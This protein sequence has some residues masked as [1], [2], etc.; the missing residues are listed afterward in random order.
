MIDYLYVI[1]DTYGR[2][3]EV[4]D[5][6]TEL[7]EGLPALLQQGWRPV[8]ETPFAGSSGI[9]AYILILL[10]RDSGPAGRY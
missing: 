4:K 3:W 9:D 6:D 5:G 8:R 2:C 1:V 7:L 10:E